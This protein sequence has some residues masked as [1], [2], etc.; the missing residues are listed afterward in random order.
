MGRWVVGSGVCLFSL[1]SQYLEKRREIES[2]TNQIAGA[3]RSGFP[4]GESTTWNQRKPD[5]GPSKYSISLPGSILYLNGFR[6]KL[7]CEDFRSFERLRLC[8][9][10]SSGGH[11]QAWCALERL[12][13]S[14]SSLSNGFR[15][16]LWW[17]DFSPAGQKCKARTSFSLQYFIISFLCFDIC[18][19]NKNTSPNTLK[20]AIGE[21]PLQF[22]PM[23]VDK[24]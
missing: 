21:V 10:I 12:F 3:T 14:P 15:A 20:K 5:D 11:A 1:S 2:R 17:D 24:S 23:Q 19:H 8:F 13:P 16:K 22:C 4:T 6:A 9:W 7:W 18:L